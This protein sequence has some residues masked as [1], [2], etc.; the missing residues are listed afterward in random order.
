MK[1][2]DSKSGP[3]H[4]GRGIVRGQ[5][6]SIFNFQFSISGGGEGGYTLVIVVLTIA[7]MS[8]MM[9]VAVQ[10]VE[11]QMRREREAELI[12]RGEQY[13][14]AIRVFKAR[15]GRYP[16]RLEEMWEAN[17]KV[18]RQ[19]WKDPMTDSEKWGL[20]FL[21]QEGRRIG[22]QNA[23]PGTPVPTETVTHQGTGSQFDEQSAFGGPG[24]EG[25]K[26]GPIVGVHSTLCEDSVKIYEGRS[27]YCEWQFVFREKGR[28][29]GT[30]RPVL[31]GGQPPGTEPTK[32]G[33]GPG[34]PG[35]PGGGGSGDPGGP[36][37]YPPPGYTPTVYQ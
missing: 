35:G 4:H 32:I 9:T 27:N 14:E 19:K 2:E 16:V 5:E 18:M 23:F 29:L 7:I 8:I 1:I 12:F 37:G 25:E 31:P 22:P 24:L 10:T 3:S 13:V 21:G 33:G 28:G 30:T 20:L 17:P 26:I 6:F 34:G 15:Y 11:F 36:G